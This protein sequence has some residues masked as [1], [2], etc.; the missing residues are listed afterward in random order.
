MLKIKEGVSVRGIRPEIM[1]AITIIQDIFRELNVDCVIT[2]AVDGQHSINSLHYV[3]F[4][5][6]IRNKTIVVG[7]RKRI[8]NRIKL[9][10]GQEY[11]VIF[12]TDH[13]H[14]EYQP[15]TQIK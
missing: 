13:Y 7:E 14:I 10:L 9:H 4:A 1:L 8:R 6:D 3:G 12:E 5:I 15:K 2:S 11:D